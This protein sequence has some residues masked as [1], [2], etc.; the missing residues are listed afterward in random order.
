M[1][2]KIVNDV[3]IQQLQL[4]INAPTQAEG[5]RL[6]SVFRAKAKADHETYMNRL[7]DEAEQGIHS[8][9]LGPVFRAIRQLAGPRASSQAPPTIN[10][11]DGSPCSSKE[12]T[13]LRW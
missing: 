9:C 11:A 6:Q 3:C 10:K 4:A 7:T 2:L 1:Y 8:N 12:E 13:L 5:K